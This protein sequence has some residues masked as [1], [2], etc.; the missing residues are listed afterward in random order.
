[1]PSKRE[2]NKVEMEIDAKKPKMANI[3]IDKQINSKETHVTK[4]LHS[5]SKTGNLELVK[6]LLQH[7]NAMIDNKNKIDIDDKNEEEMTAL[8]LAAENGHAEIVAEL[9]A[10]GAD[11]NLYNGCDEPRKCGKN[12][13]TENALH[14][15][16]KMGHFEVVKE[17]LKHPNV[18]IDAWD[19]LTNWTS[20]HQASV[21]RNIEILTL[22]LA[23]GANG[24]IIL[25]DNDD[26]LDQY[27]RD[28]T[29]LH[30]T[31]RAGHSEIVK[32]LLKYKID[33]DFNNK[34]G[35]TALHIASEKGHAEIVASLLD[36]GANVKLFTKHEHIIDEKAMHMASR[37]GH[38]ETV[39]ELLKHDKDIDFKN[40]SGQSSLHVAA[41]SRQTLIVKELIKQGA[42]IDLH[43][44][45]K[46]E[47]CIGANGICDI[48]CYPKGNA[49]YLASK[50][51]YADI[52]KFLLLHGAKVTMP[53]SPDALDIACQEGHLEVVKE[54]I[55][56]GASIQPYN[57]KLH[58]PDV[59]FWRPKP[60]LHRAVVF[61]RIE[62]VKELLK[63]GAKVNHEDDFYGTPINIVAKTGNLPIAKVLMSYGANPYYELD[64]D[65]DMDWSGDVTPLGNAMNNEQYLIVEEMLIHGEID[66][67]IDD[68]NCTALHSAC[69]TGRV[70]SVTQLLAKGFNPN[71]LDKNHQTP[72]HH[73]IEGASIYG[74]SDL[75]TDLLNHGADINIQDDNGK[76]AFHKAF[77]VLPNDKIINI[78]LQERHNYNFDLKDK[79]GKTVL[80]IAIEKR[81]H[82]V[83][84]M[85]AKRMCPKPKITNSIYPL[86]YLM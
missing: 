59:E 77:N 67:I 24:N 36:Y 82:A 56:C 79:N 81:N 37:R 8:H 78:L 63:L 46:P 39:R 10:H 60:P 14:M 48:E 21:D 49:L 15:A 74:A 12:C 23:H 13:K 53:C 3:N 25:G 44:G 47:G 40:E 43:V 38:L 16:T 33:V 54:L 11:V 64:G 66:T 22:L 68:Q 1:M 80:D 50:K 61:G 71:S 83:A 65:L 62:V 30:D 55:N 26:G 45:N 57:E 69:V 85:I 5:F 18:N 35:E 19:G 4:L 76:T 75:V 6:K 31:S 32:E 28:T 17:I 7:N 41:E 52:V 20:L 9:L 70:K 73:S 42:K 58:D 2:L 34:D 29:I 51:G 86:K 84:R 27:I 72:L